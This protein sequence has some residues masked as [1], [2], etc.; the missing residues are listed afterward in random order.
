MHRVAKKPVSQM[1]VLGA[2]LLY[3]LWHLHYRIED[4]FRCPGKRSN[5]FSYIL[6]AWFGLEI[7]R[8]LVS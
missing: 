2:G 8:E 7:V 3:N 1:K 5:K 6:F 4:C